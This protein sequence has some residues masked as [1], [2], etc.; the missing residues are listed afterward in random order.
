M[1]KL[2]DLLAHGQSIWLDY[3]RRDFVAT[4]RL[5]ALIDDGL[6]GLTSNPSIFEKAIA[7][8]SEYE[9]DLAKFA[10]GGTSAKD[11]YELLAV[12]D[13]Q[14][15]ADAFRGVYD[16]SGRRDGF[17]SLEVSPELARDTEATLIEAR[18]LWRS[19]SRENLM[20]KV[21]GTPEGLPAIETLISEGINVN[22]TLLFSVPVYESVAA[23]YLTGLERRA[24]AGNDIAGTAS[25]ASFFVSRVDSA[26]DKL[27]DARRQTAD[28][29]DRARVDALRGKTAIANA[30]LAYERFGAILSTQQWKRLA[31]QGA[32]PQRLLW[33]ST[34]TKDPA[35]SD[36]LYLEE[37]I[38]RDTVNT[39]PPKTLEAFV[40]HGRIRDSLS[41]DV[42]GAH[43]TL[44][45]LPSV[46]ISLEDV[47]R[48]LLEDGQR[49]FADDFRKL[50]AAV[51]RAREDCAKTA[52]SR[53]R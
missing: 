45:A 14:R 35:Y 23:R 51:G 25:V 9:A 22:V 48:R 50:L 4:G 44:E 32:Q 36:V 16:A 40:D 5:K 20:I 3:I 15:A 31:S 47:T 26:V 33:A 39:A 8:D 17:V 34:G 38:G 43:A 29:A 10:A 6:R 28:E 13:L 11:I 12:A 37:L 7:P 49:L 41:E 24:A 53:Q 27:L 46:G 19:V 21:P 42:Q 2:K 52:V 1:S 30:K 18:R